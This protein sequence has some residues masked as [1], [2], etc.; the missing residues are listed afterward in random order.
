MFVSEKIVFLELHKTGGSHIGYLLSRLLEG[1]QVG[2]H[3]TLKDLYRNRT[4]L[5]SIRNPWDWYVSLWAYGCGG[6]GSVMRQSGKRFDLDYCY[7]QLPKEM[8]RN[9]LKPAHYYRLFTSE[10][11]KNAEDWKWCYED[12]QDPARF[13]FWLELL[14]SGER[15]L[16]IG[17]GYGF[18]PISDKFGLLTYR[19]FKLFT[20]SR[21]ELYT[22]PA[23]AT[24]RGLEL[25]QT[26]KSLVHFVIKT[27]RL[28]ADLLDALSKS[29]IL[30]SN[31]Q[32]DTILKGSKAKLNK[33]RR[34]ST[35]FYYDQ[36]ALA[37]V[38]E[39]EK[40]IIQQYNYLQ[41][42]IK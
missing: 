29:G 28:E 17:E 12:V 14:L 37:L 41:P 15:A 36:K 18:S 11:T 26:N 9:W 8:G 25:L 20:D 35:A 31:D 10:W 1:E 2:K 22:N 33:S 40:F 4:I 5:G 38:G 21:S 19:Y 7:R 6:G 16:D 32:R 23:L 13:R 27:E 3:N 39:K 30:I 34:N 42:N 24:K